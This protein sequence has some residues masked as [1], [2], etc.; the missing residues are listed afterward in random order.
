MMSPTP[1]SLFC[2]LL[3]C[4]PLA[5]VF[6]VVTPPA[7][8]IR[9]ITSTST[10]T[11][12]TRTNPETRVIET[13]RITTTTISSSL[14]ARPPSTTED[15]DQ[16]LFRRAAGVKPDP[17]LP[18]RLAFMFLTTT[19]LPFAPLW[20]LFFNSTRAQEKLY[21]IYV[22]ADPSFPYDPPFSGVFENRVIP[23]SKPTR[24]H[25]PT[26]ISAARRLLSHA[27]LEDPSNSMFALLSSACIPLHS[28]DFTYEAL[29][30][31][32]KSFI[33]ILKDE[34]GAWARWAARGERVMLP[35]LPFEDFRIGSQFFVLTRKHAR[36][37]ANETRLWSKFKLTCLRKNKNTCYPEEHY[38]PSL[39]SMEDP[40]GCVPATLTH[41][42]WRGRHDGHPRTY[43]VSEVGPK[44]ILALRK[45]VPRYGVNVDGTNGSH[46]S[47][48][49]RGD[50][51][52]FARKFSPDSIATLVRIANDVIF[53]D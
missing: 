5:I 32:D 39:I 2:V 29:V 17:L 50:P 25:S 40:R 45:D 13:T 34:P 10:S 42:D 53:K 4:L 43:G 30:K 31:S 19:P 3:I 51:F 46:S 49:K 37:V 18:K 33:E 11:S 47:M 20:E 38:F 36:L 1:L 27:L 8:T 9:S 7:T 21:N 12:Q 16:M 22:H 44:L 6:T 15:D 14:P 35:E 28:F 26:L 52:L 41:V 24:R 23:E 48:R